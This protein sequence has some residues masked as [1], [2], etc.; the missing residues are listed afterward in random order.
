MHY[1]RARDG[2]PVDRTEACTPAGMVKPGYSVRVA[3]IADGQRV[4]LADSA[5][6]TDGAVT[7]SDAESA[8]AVGQARRQHVGRHGYLGSRAPAFTD[9]HAASAVARAVALKQAATVLPAAVLVQDAVTISSRFKFDEA[10][11]ARKTAIAN[12]WRK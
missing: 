12:A 9:A 6:I 11:R 2:H 5:P 10:K 3:M 4:S 7:L 1:I 8:L